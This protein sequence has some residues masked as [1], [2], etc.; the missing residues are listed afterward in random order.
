[1][2]SNYHAVL[3]LSALVAT[4]ATISACGSGVISGDTPVD[5]PP[6]ENP[7]VENPPADLATAENL[8]VKPEPAT[9]SGQ[10]GGV[11]PKPCA[12]ASGLGTYVGQD[13]DEGHPFIITHDISCQDALSNCA[14]NISQ[15]PS[16]NL[17]CEWNGQFLLQGGPDPSACTKANVP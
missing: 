13:C 1:M 17:S 10:C 4:G 5:N 12:H 15:N 11:P 2:T 16:M 3:V 8:P 6:A 14:L 7:S 9:Q